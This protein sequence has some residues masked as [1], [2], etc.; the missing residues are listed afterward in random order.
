MRLVRKCLKICLKGKTP[1]V[2]INTVSPGGVGRRISIV[3]F[4]TGE[5]LLETW[6]Q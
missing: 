3:Q 4:I 6:T 1:E 2:N 5:E